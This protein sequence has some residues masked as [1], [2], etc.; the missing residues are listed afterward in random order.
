MSKDLAATSVIDLI[1]N[2]IK[3]L[4]DDYEEAKK[5]FLE[6]WHDAGSIHDWVMPLTFF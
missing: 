4:A 5:L 1:H 3:G 6:I 2:L